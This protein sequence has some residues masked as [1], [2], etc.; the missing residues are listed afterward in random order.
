MSKKVIKP[1]EIYFTPDSGAGSIC[2]FTSDDACEMF[3]GTVGGALFELKAHGEVVFRCRKAD[4]R[5][6]LD[7]K[8]NSMESIAFKHSME[9]HTE[10]AAK[11]KLKLN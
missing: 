6:V 8:H 5:M 4:I 9:Q 2:V 7:V 11:G 1:Y 10:L 3:D